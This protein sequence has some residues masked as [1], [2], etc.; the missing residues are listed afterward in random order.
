MKTFHLIKCGKLIFHKTLS[1]HSLINLGKMMTL[2]IF[3]FSVVIFSFSD[4][5]RKTYIVETEGKMIEQ[6]VRSSFN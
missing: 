4:N 6:V 2:K 5:H 1:F 3:L